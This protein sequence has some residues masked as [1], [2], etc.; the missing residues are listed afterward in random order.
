MRAVYLYRKFGHSIAVVLYLFS[1]LYYTIYFFYFIL[2]FFR[3]S[4]RDKKKIV[5]LAVWFSS[6]RFQFFSFVLFFTYTS[7]KK[8]NTQK[9]FSSIYEVWSRLSSHSQCFLFSFFDQFLFLNFSNK[10]VLLN[11]CY[12]RILCK[13]F[14]YVSVRHIIYSWYVCINFGW[15]VLY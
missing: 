13:R 2:L 12:L 8:K 9:F 11:E 4:A 5:T 1:K 6:S 10:N 7:L 3:F 15:C 14:V